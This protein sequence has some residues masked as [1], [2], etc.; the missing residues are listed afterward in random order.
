[1][2]LSAGA[3]GSLV[4]LDEEEDAAGAGT[5]P[6]WRVIRALSCGGEAPRSW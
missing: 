6:A 2:V 4:L 3:A 1:M 5:G